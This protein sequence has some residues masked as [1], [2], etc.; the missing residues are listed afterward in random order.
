MYIF[1]KR[2]DDKLDYK[3]TAIGFPKHDTQRQKNEP[4]EY[5]FQ[6]A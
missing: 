2:N 4:W 5:S 3:G 1:F 6:G